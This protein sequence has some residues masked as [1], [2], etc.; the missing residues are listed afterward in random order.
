MSPNVFSPSIA[1]GLLACLVLTLTPPIDAAPKPSRPSIH[2]HLHGPQSFFARNQYRPRI[3][4]TAGK[5]NGTR[6]PVSITFSTMRGHIARIEA[7][8]DGK[9]VASRDLEQIM[10][11]GK[12][13]TTIELKGIAPGP[14]KITLW[15]WQGRQGYQSLHGESLTLKLTL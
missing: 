5:L 7:R 11:N 6:L 12:L 10:S 8:V 4:F 1:A 9:V 14:H 2:R 15:A 3:R 13:D